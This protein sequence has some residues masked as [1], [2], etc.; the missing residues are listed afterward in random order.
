[1]INKKLIE[2]NIIT[3]G[4]SENTSSLAVG[5]KIP[6]DT[7]FN[8]I[9]NKLTINSGGIK[10]G[11]GVSKVLVSGQIQIQYSSTN[12]QYSAKAYKNSTEITGAYTSQYKGGT[13]PITLTI[14]PT[15]VNVSKNDV[16]YLY[17]TY[18]SSVIRPESYLTVEVME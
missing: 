13:A 17:L 16:I 1:M 6:F 18:G 3:I 12:Q 8:S 2:K 11:S 5:S 10:I 9:G 15:L 7:T 4:L 14:S